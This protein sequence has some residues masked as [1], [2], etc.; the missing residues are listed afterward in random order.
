[1][2]LDQAIN[3]WFHYEEIAMH[4]NELIIQYRLQLMGGAGAIGA[5]A[6]YLVGSKVESEIDRHKLRALISTGLLIIFVSAAYLDLFYYNELLR[7]S[8]DALIELEAKYPELNMSTSIKARFPNG[9]TSRIYITYL[10]VLIPLIFFTLW[11][12]FTCKPKK[13]K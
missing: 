9:A 13:I 8:V 7:G 10:L 2:E 12:W 11:S 4:F 1:M 6:S 5:I 3:L